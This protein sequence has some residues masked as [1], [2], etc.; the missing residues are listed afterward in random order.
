MNELQIFENKN[1]GKIRAILRDGEPWFVA[2]DVCKALEI[3]NPTDAIK[4]LDEDERARFNLGHPYGDTN[5]V[6]EPGLYSLVLGSRKPEAKTFKRWIVHDVIPVIRKHGMY[7]TPETI[8]RMFTDTDFIIALGKKLKEEQQKRMELEGKLEADKPYTDFARSIE[9][10]NGSVHIGSFAKVVCN[11]GI[12][13]GRNRLLEWLREMRYLMRDND[14]Y[15]RYIDQGIFQVKE[16]TVWTSG[17]ALPKFT[18]F[19]TGKGQLTL[20][21][22]LREDFCTVM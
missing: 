22:A 14:P 20:L 13:I 15:Q 2:A 19:V 11:S 5:I 6:N 10:S 18:T 1:L 7:A 3:A 17:G 8:E 21:K 4:R 9:T 16:Y 12:N